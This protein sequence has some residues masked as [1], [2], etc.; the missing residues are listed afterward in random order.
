M[1]GLM[2]ASLRHKHDMQHHLHTVQF[3]MY[4]KH[5]AHDENCKCSSTLFIFPF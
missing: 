4:T 2:C 3:V 5:R 1:D